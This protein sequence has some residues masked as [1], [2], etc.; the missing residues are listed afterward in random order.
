MLLAASAALLAPSVARAQGQFISPGPLSTN[1]QDLDNN[2]FACHSVSRGVD[3][4]LCMSCHDSVR[5]QVSTGLGFHSDKGRDC[6]SCHHEH[7]GRSGPALMPRVGGDPNFDHS[8]T[9]FP[10]KGAHATA[11]CEDCHTEPG[12]FTGLQSTCVS[13]HDDPHGQNESKRDLLQSCDLCHNETEWKALPLP[14]F[15]FDHTSGAQTD[16]VLE[17]KHIDVYCAD[18]HFDWRFV[19]IDHDR[20][21]DCHEDPHRADF[22][23]DTCEDCHKSPGSWNVPKFDHRRTPYALE[24]EHAKVDCFSCHKGNATVPLAFST[25]EDCHLDMHSGQFRPRPCE[26]CHTVQV[27]KFALRQFDHDA[28]NFPLVGLHFGVNCEDCHGDRE[29]ALYVGK[30]FDDCDTCHVDEHQGRFEPTLCQRCHTPEG[31]KALFFNHDDTNFPH[32]GKHK[33]VECNGCHSDF[34]WV[35]F[36]YGSCADCHQ[37]ASPHSPGVMGPETCDSCHD[38][39]AFDIITFDHKANTTFDLQPAHT[40]RKCVDCHESVDKFAGLNSDCT[41]CHK[42][43]RPWGHYDGE[44][45]TCHKASQW[46]PGGLGDQDH[47]VTGFALRGQHAQ[48]DCESCHPPDRARGEATPQCSSCHTVDDPHKNQLGNVCDDCHNDV[49]WF[50]VR[51]RHGS[52]GFPLRGGHRVADCIDCHPNSYTGT[53]NECFRCHSS[54]ASNGPHHQSAVFRDCQLCHREYAWTPPIYFGAGLGAGQ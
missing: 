19:P 18:C 32:T 41:A 24:G 12:K 1:H 6:E 25:C 44:C 7:R 23:K 9:G 51:W 5:N 8:T 33:Q 22:G 40:E 48:L 15:V 37:E 52:T 17:G 20:C 10:L 26:E 28:T 21:L 54:Q 31:F 50:R 36:P 16:Y 2:C 53:P 30:P 49:S 3:E 4:T 13:C 45:G 42:S 34:Q 11:A 35:G 46:F 47:A 39:E 29:E 14:K 38:T 43:D 27:P